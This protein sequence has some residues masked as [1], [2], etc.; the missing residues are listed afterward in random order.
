MPQASS[1]ISY[2]GSWS[3]SYAHKGRSPVARQVTKF[4]ISAGSHLHAF[5][6]GSSSEPATEHT[7]FETQV[8]APLTGS[9]VVSNPTLQTQALVATSST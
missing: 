8:K 5:A 4:K 9:T 6:M 2:L 3:Q 1:M 7:M